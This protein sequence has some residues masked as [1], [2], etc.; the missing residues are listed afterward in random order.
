MMGGIICDVLQVSVA[1]YNH[2]EKEELQH[3]VSVMIDYNLTYSQERSQ[4]GSFN[5]NLDP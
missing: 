3:V 4:E 2:S 1:M 5:F